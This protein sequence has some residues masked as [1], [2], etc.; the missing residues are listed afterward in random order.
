[1]RE[2]IQNYALHPLTRRPEKSNYFC[3]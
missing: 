2:V 3:A 1:M